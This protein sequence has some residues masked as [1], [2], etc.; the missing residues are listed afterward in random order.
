M[1]HGAG[2]VSPYIQVSARHQKYFVV[3]RQNA[4]TQK[5]PYRGFAA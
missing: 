5:K 3:I 1:A 4:K 2:S